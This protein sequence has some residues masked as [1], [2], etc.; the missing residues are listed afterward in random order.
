M[1]AE[2]ESLFQVGNRVVLR[3]SHSHAGEA[4][5]IVG[6][7]ARVFNGWTVKLDSGLHVGVGDEQMR[8]SRPVEREDGEA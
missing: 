6:S 3:G 4:G 2:R 5:R 1:S 7:R 8:A